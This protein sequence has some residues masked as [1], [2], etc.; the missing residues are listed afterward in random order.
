METITK[1]MLTVLYSSVCYLATRC[2]PV[3]WQAAIIFR[4]YFTPVVLHVQLMFSINSGYSHK[5]DET[6]T[7]VGYFTVSCGDLCGL[8]YSEL[9]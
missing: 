5:A 4:H 9:W 8:L 3:T 7:V 6:C 1:Q 2:V